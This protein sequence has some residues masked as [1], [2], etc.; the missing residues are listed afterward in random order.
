VIDIRQRSATKPPLDMEALHH[1]FWSR[2]W[3]CT[4]RHPCKH[5]CWPWLQPSGIYRFSDNAPVYTNK[6]FAPHQA[7]TGP[8]FAY[9]LKTGMP[10]FASSFFHLCHQCDL[11]SCLN[12]SHIILGSASDNMKDMGKRFHKGYKPIRLPDGRLLSPT[13]RGLEGPRR[14][15][16]ARSMQKYLQAYFG[17]YS[18]DY[19]GP[20]GYAFTDALCQIARPTYLAKKDKPRAPEDHQAFLH[21]LITNLQLRADLA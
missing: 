14:T 2:V 9:F 21:A 3:R 12:P 5:C 6:Q 16:P 18:N 20:R 11:K 15:T 19:D 17:L 10:I 13:S 7:M 8:R 1:H 4:H